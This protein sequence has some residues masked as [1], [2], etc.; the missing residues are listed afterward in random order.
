MIYP[1]GQPAQHRV[2]PAR[3]IPV[4]PAGEAEMIRLTKDN[5]ELAVVPASPQTGD[6]AVL[7][8]GRFVKLRGKSTKLAVVQSKATIACL[9]GVLLSGCMVTG[10]SAISGGR[11]A[12]N[13]A[14]VE[15]DNQQ[16]LLVVVRN[17]YGERSNLLAVSSVTANIT[18]AVNAGVEA[19]VGDRDNYSGNLV[20]FKAG[21]LYEE[22]PTISYT[23][24][25]GEKY[26][27][28]I[29][30]PVTVTSLAQLTE[31]LVDPAPVYYA[32]V[33][34]INGIYNP[35]FLSRPDTS[36][37]R[38]VR[39]VE[40]MTE[41]TQAHRLHWIRDSQQADRFSITIDHY[42]TDYADRVNELLALLGISIPGNH[43][44]RII[45]PVSLAVD[46][47][48]AGG[49]GIITRSVFDLLEILTGAVE[50]PEEDLA[51][52][53]AI[54]YPPPGAVGEQLK[55]RYS[56]SRPAHASVA[57]QYRDGWFYIDDKDQA[58]KLYFRL[59]TT[60]LSVNIAES[61]GRAPAAPV[62]TVPVSR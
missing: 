36:D 5:G 38:F 23:P 57:V 9:L 7:P 30:S 11:L 22:N 21:V 10:P 54:R 52:G 25:G 17:R 20:P 6:R 41:L 28:K 53:V 55:V 59:L 37:K 3:L 60:L 49:I 61:T 2:Q 29:M 31:N 42:L 1:P 43:S 32:L 46:G 62:L 51:S 56:G 8:R 58:T 14:I 4:L 24:V 26:A 19:G 39:I 44:A 27:N 18:V 12:Y 48:D 33:S 50:V 35:E 40:I 15:T 47:V 45:L 16:M 13:D 34:S